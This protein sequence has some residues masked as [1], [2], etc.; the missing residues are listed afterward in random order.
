MKKL[1]KYSVLA[2]ALALGSSTY[3]HAATV[4][5]ASGGFAGV[6]QDILDFL[7]HHNASSHHTNSNPPLP[8]PPREPRGSN[9]AP[10]VDP[11]LAMSAFL[12]IGGTLTVLRSRRSRLSKAN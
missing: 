3:A 4:S 9:A 12:L 10:E 11:N 8:P 6:I 2:L 1:L 7:F 5:V